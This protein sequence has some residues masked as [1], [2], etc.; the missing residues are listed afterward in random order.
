MR[1]RDAYDPFRALGGALALIRRAP[2][3]IV[4]GALLVVICQPSFS[5]QLRHLHRDWVVALVCA[6]CSLSVVLYGL[7]SL[8]SLGFATALER[9]AVKGEERM[10]DLFRARGRFWSMLFGQLLSTLLAGLALVPF[11]LF[12]AA[13]GVMAGSLG[14]DEAGVAVGVLAFLVV[15]PGWIY[16]LLGLALAPHAI[17]FER[18][19]PFEAVARSWGLVRGNRLWLFWYLLVQLVF[20]AL[21]LCCC[22]VGVFATSAVSTIAGYEAYLRLTRDDHERWAIEGGAGA[23]LKSLAP[24]D[25]DDSAW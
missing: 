25:P 13:L 7:L 16:L 15:S 8:F 1:F 22:V 12:A 3:T 6:L 10:G 18:M 17:A 2:L 14:G 5:I 9:V 21:G 23:P 19:A 20:V 11:L 24:D 4:T